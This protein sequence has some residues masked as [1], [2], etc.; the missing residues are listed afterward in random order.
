MRK[1]KSYGEFKTAVNA[2]KSLRN[3]N[4]DINAVSYTHLTLPTSD[5]IENDTII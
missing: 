5:I 1:G 4:N 2:Y 3:T